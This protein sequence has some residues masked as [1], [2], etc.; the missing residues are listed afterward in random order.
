MDFAS[1][2]LDDLFG[3]HSTTFVFKGSG[4]MSPQD[5]EYWNRGFDMGYNFTLKHYKNLKY[6][7]PW[8]DDWGNGFGESGIIGNGWAE[9]CSSE[10]SVIIEKEYPGLLSMSLRPDKKYDLVFKDG[11]KIIV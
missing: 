9:G 10:R 2:V 11:R 6:E 5:S 4:Y 7:M 8:P 1:K 3:H